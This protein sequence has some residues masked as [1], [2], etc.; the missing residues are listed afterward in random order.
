MLINN[1]TQR[2]QELKQAARA[3]RRGSF[4][5]EADEQRRRRGTKPT[6]RIQELEQ[7][8]KARRR[9]AVAAE[10]DEQRRRRG[11]KPTE[12]ILVLWMLF[13]LALNFHS[14][15]AAAEVERSVTPQ[16]APGSLAAYRIGS[17]PKALRKFAKSEYFAAGDLRGERHFALAQKKC[18]DLIKLETA[19]L[20]PE[21]PF[22]L[23]PLKELSMIYFDQHND[24]KLAE[25][26]KRI[27]E[28][29]RTLVGPES[30]DAADSFVRYLEALGRMRGSEDTVKLA[31]QRLDTL[32]HCTAH[33]FYARA[34]VLL[35]LA[36]HL[37][38]TSD[39]HFYARWAAKD[40]VQIDYVDRD[41]MIFFLQEIGDTLISLKERASA[42][43]LYGRVMELRGRRSS[44]AD[45][46][47]VKTLEILSKLQLQ[48]GD[49]KGAETTATWSAG[50]YRQKRDG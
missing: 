28:M 50:I 6:E 21:H 27:D 2:I 15:L 17:I 31:S 42:M 4:A 33:G 25:I 35:F 8:A 37:D 12:R 7:A 43:T 40:A 38:S 47:I 10:A 26:L 22:I 32:M 34:K 24:S 16:A 1:A 23:L 49:L 13:S 3:R 30:P 41:G 5:A 36:Q 11:T 14:P 39:A 46:R 19:E 20:G 48:A 45:S 29:Q 18:L 44:T 9:G